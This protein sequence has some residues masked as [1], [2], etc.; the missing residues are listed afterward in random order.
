M[1][2]PM[3]AAPQRIAAAN[4]MSGYTTGNSVLFELIQQAD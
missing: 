3:N 4:R 1:V 2:A